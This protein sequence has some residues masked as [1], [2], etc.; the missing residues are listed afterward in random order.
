M[1]NGDV[2]VF[3]RFRPINKMETQFSTKSCVQHYDRKRFKL[4][5][6]MLESQ[7]QKDIYGYTFAFDRVF[8]SRSSQRDIFREIGEP[9]IENTLTGFN[10]TLIAYGQTASGKTYT[11]IGESIY[12]SSLSKEGLISRIMERI[13]EDLHQNLSNKDS[14]LINFEVTV[15]MVEIHLERV[16]IY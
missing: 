7:D 12:E 1:E 3:C 2:K 13:L 5:D 8:S 4:V 9:I 10:S 6:T 15:S 14:N 16:R 11:M